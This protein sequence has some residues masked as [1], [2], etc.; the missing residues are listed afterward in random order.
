MQVKKE[1]VKIQ[2][3]VHPQRKLQQ[4]QKGMPGKYIILPVENTAVTW[5]VFL[6]S[7]EAVSGVDEE[8]AGE[9]VAIVAEEESTEK[10]AKSSM[11][12]KG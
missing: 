5:V 8:E 3:Q 4:D 12:V 11:P 2:P 6:T 1:Q 9:D 7:K 10:T